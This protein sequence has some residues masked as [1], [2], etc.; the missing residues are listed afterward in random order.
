M[1]EPV[2]LDRE[3]RLGRLERSN[4]RYRAAFVASLAALGLAAAG[5]TG[6]ALHGEGS[7]GGAV[8]YLS[9][10]RGSLSFYGED[11]TVLDRIPAPR[12]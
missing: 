10:G 11:G 6:F 12:S 7:K 9:K 1:E 8:L 2:L 5:G 4:R 3:G